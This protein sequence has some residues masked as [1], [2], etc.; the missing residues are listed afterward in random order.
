MVTKKDYIEYLI[1]TPVNYTCTNLAKHLEDVS[2]DAVNDYLH[3]ERLT[4]HHL[5]EQVK[6]LLNDRPETYLIVDDSVQAKKHAHKMDL[7]QRQYSGNE[8]SVVK[9]IGVVNLVHTDGEDYY[10]I[11]FRIYAK[12]MDGK[13]KNDHFREM[14][15]NAKQDKNIQANTVLFDSWY[16]SWENLKCVHRLGMVFFTTLKSN[17][18]VSLSREAG[19]IHLDEIEWTDERLKEGVSVKLQKVPFRVQLFKVVTPHGDIDW[20]ITNSDAS[21]TTDDVQDADT[22]RW[23]VEQLHRELKQLTSIIEKCQCRKQRAQR[24]HI[25]CCYQAWL[26]IK[27][28]ADELGKTL[29]ATVHDLLYEFLRAE[30]RDP[31]IPALEVT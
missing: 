30:L 23:Q 27:V 6:P 25:A 20:I 28:K 29:Y 7:V 12:D 2:H 19:Y 21:L 8:G 24:N 5:W 3:R 1:S 22:R 17:R 31:C 15:L 14:L 10:P 4:A 13:T 9:G 11:D 18:L 16:G 26:A